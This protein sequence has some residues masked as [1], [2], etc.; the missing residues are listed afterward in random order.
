VSIS[1]RA[2]KKL[3]NHSLFLK[4]VHRN[5]KFIKSISQDSTTE[6][7][8]I[9]AGLQHIPKIAIYAVIFKASTKAIKICIAAE[10]AM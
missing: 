10:E 2:Q 1:L 4:N 3:I 6:L 5:I 8:R 9:F 7:H